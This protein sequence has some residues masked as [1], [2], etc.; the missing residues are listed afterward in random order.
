MVAPPTPYASRRPWEPGAASTGLDRALDTQDALYRRRDFGPVGQSSYS[1][2]KCRAVSPMAHA[3][4]EWHTT[5]RYRWR[6]VEIILCLLRHRV[7]TRRSCALQ[8]GSSILPRWLRSRNT[9]GRTPGAVVSHE[10]LAGNH[11]S[12]RASSC[13]TQT[14]AA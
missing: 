8:N 12:A 7:D 1:P 11:H 13:L 9:W 2:R 3:E 10:V 14:S 6:A 4:C 5:G